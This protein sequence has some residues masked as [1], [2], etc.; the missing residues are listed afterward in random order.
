MHT[1]RAF[2]TEGVQGALESKY[3][4]AAVTLLD[5]VHV[6]A[7]NNVIWGDFEFGFL[8]S[9]QGEFNNFYNNLIVLTSPYGKDSPFSMRIAACA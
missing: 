1:P 5:S 3:Y 7:V 4:Y 9:E 8:A 6:T 2:M